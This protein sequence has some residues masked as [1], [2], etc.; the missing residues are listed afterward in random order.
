MTWSPVNW[1]QAWSSYQTSLQQIGRN[2]RLRGNSVSRADPAL[3]RAVAK[4]G[5]L[6]MRLQ[7]RPRAGRSW[8]GHAERPFRAL[9]GLKNSRAASAALNRDPNG[10]RE[11][12]PGQYPPNFVDV[13]L[14]VP[15]DRP[16]IAK[17]HGWPGRVAWSRRGFAAR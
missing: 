9:F 16:L 14:A 15:A 1:G 13:S 10:R 7:S 2:A 17:C 4:N 5:V 12:R 6:K 11:G 3:S 8:R